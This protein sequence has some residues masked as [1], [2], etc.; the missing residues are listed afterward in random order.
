MAETKAVVL[1]SGGLDSST[2]LAIARRKLEA[3][4]ISS[5]ELNEVLATGETIHSIPIVAPIA[6][7]IQHADI[8]PG[9]LTDLFLSANRQNVP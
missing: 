1:L 5:A 6:G 3:L 9:Q 7:T 8:R 2:T 4:G